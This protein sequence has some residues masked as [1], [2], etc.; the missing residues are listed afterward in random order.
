MKTS[1]WLAL[2]FSLLA[3]EMGLVGS[4]TVITSFGIRQVWQV[5]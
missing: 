2:L 5:P 4:V 3:L 1:Y